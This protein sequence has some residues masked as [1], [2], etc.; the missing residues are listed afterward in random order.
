MQKIFSYSLLLLLFAACSSSKQTT[1][2]EDTTPSWL[3]D[4][5][6][7]E[8][9]YTGIGIANKSKNPVDYIQIAQQNALQNLASQIKVNIATQSVFLQMEREYG[10]EEEFKSD[11]RIKAEEHLE[12]YELKGTHQ[13]GDEYWVYYSLSKAKYAEVRQARMEQ[14]M[15]QAKALLTFTTHQYSVKERYINFV[16]ALEVLKPYLSEPLACRLESRNV[17][18]GSE[19]IA[20]FRNFMDDFRILSLNKKVKVMLGNKLGELKFAVEFNED[21]V[22]NIPLVFVSDIID[23]TPFSSATDERGIFTAIVPKITSTESVQ[24]MQIGLDIEQWLQEATQDKFIKKLAR[25]IKSHQINLPVYVYTPLVYV[26]SREKHFG[27]LY[28]SQDLKFAAETA[29]NKMGFTPT[30]NKDEAELFM[31]IE[32][33]TEKGREQVEQKMFTAF[34]NMS[35]QVKDKN[36]MIVFSEQ[37]NKLKGIQLSFEQANTIAYENAQEELNKSIIPDFVDS[38]IQQ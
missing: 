29:L 16:K 24:K 8:N 12:G 34:L 4:Y 3:K 17:F 27:T 30:G 20:Q 6:V 22:D 11:I 9:H 19:V 37:L 38:F 23:V 26:Q 5:P 10:F 21:R 31:T 28:R 14:A 32:A 25:G 1:V 18:L 15:E 2:V 33:N 7:S 35:V 36:D 13:A